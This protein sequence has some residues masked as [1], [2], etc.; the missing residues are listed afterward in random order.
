VVEGVEVKMHLIK[1]DQVVDQVAVDKVPMEQ[2][3]QVVQ[4]IIHQL[5]HLKVRVVE[6]GMVVQMDLVVEQVEQV[7]LVALHLFLK[8]E[9]VVMELQ[10]Q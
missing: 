9:Q 8:V 6:V 1:L 2:Q 3:V 10:L 7:D 5:V 4:E